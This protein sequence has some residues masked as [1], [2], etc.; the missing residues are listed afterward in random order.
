MPLITDFFG[1]ASI[2]TNRAVA[3][4]VSADRTAGVD[5]LSC[6]DLS[7]FTEDTPVYF[8]TYTKTTDPLTGDVSIT[9]TTSWKGIV[10]AGANTITNLEVAPG[11][12]DAGNTEDQFVECIP[13]SYWANELVDGILTEH[14]QDGTH[15]DITADSV[16]VGTTLTMPDS[17]VTTAKLADSSVTAAKRTGGLFI[18]DG[19]GS[20]SNTTYTHVPT[21]NLTTT[22]DR[23]GTDVLLML[24]GWVQLPNGGSPIGL[25]Y[26]IMDSNDGTG[27]TIAS[28][29]VQMGTTNTSGVGVSISGK[30]TKNTGTHTFSVVIQRVGSVLSP[31]L[32]G[33]LIGILF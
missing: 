11:Y 9:D 13:T 18:K 10:N 27:T 24:Q 19:S 4:T 6:F 22:V 8:V 25:S 2:D 7:S 16:T 1:K 12:T 32:Y 26:K 14:K 33:N 15:S 23:D 29:T 5:V 31:T 30:I 3:T 17:T 21:F 20:T 28:G